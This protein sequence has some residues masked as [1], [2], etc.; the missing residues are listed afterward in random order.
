MLDSEVSELLAELLAGSK[1]PTHHGA[2]GRAH[3]GGHL[4]VGAGLEVDEL[5]HGSKRL[6]QRV[7]RLL[8]VV[9][10]SRFQ[11]LLRRV[12]SSLM[13]VRAEEAISMDP[14]PLALEHF[15]LLSPASVLIDEGV[16]LDSEQ[17]RPAIGSGAKAIPCAIC[18]EEGLL[19]EIFGVSF[20]AGESQPGSIEHVQVDERCLFEIGSLFGCHGDLLAGAPRRPIRCGECPVLNN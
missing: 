4:F 12:A 15:A 11:E 20:V 5:H 14:V 19:N 8:H 13:G 1:Q 3:D 9:T 17:P 2:N 6:G 16:A 10:E 7:Q 18:S